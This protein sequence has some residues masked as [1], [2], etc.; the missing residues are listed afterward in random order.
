MKGL[1]E[2]LKNLLRNA[3][4]DE[5]SRKELFSHLLNQKHEEIKSAIEFDDDLFRFGGDLNLTEEELVVKKK[6]Q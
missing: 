2:C 4:Q 6:M 5:N 3:S 1:N